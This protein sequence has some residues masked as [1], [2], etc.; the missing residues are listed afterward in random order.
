VS[1]F[2]N[3]KSTMGL[4]LFKRPTISL[5]MG[6]LATT[7]TFLTLILKLPTIVLLTI[8]LYSIIA[9]RLP[10]WSGVSSRISH[11]K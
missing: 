8:Y 5:A 1:K 6:S 9:L 7:L 2:Y 10:I 4:Q 3:N 11:H